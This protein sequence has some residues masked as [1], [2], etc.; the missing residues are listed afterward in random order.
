MK[1]SKKWKESYKPLGQPEMLQHPNHRGARRRRTTARNWKLIW[2]NNEGKLPTLVKE[3]DF[4]EAQT[5]PQ[6]LD[7]RKHT[8]RHVIITLAKIKDKE[9]ILEAARKK[10]TV[11]LQRTSH[12]TV[13]WFLKRNLAGKKGL[14][15]SIQSYKRQGPTSKVPL[16]SKAII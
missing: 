1:N 13:S 7:L 6:K 15:R 10:D 11:N 12:K 9:R 5:V 8:L 14:A 16:L 2:I 4:Q 3:I